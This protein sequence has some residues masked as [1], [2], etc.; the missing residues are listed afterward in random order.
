MNKKILFVFLI[1]VSFAM[2]ISACGPDQSAEVP[3]EEA[4]VEEPLSTP[5]K[6]LSTPPIKRQRLQ[7]KP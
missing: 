6:A 5:V 1:L 7:H 2:L 3:E 4:V